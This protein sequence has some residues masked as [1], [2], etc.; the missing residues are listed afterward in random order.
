MTDFTE[1]LERLIHDCRAAAENV[2]SGV[3][4]VDDVE[5][6]AGLYVMAREARRAASAAEKAVEDRL[7][8]CMGDTR[9]LEVQGVGWVEKKAKIRR[10]GW[11]HDDLYR[12]I[13][14]RAEPAVDT[15]TGEIVRDAGWVAYDTLKDWAGPKWRVTA[16]RDAELQADEYCR[17]QFDRW[18]VRVT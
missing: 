11:R 10:T 2:E 15:D 3:S 4:D 13:E 16:L 8:E 1:H 6:L 7:A 14:K 12:E 5:D 18:E 17:E 9:Q